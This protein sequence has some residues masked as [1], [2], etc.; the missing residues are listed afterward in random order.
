MEK[1]IIVY[2]MSN[3]IFCINLKKWM[4][5]NQIQYEERNIINSLEH[6]QEFNDLNGVGVPLIV[7]KSNG[8]D[9]IVR[10]FNQRKLEELLIN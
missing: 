1:K 8:K 3:C 7:I 6:E 4:E 10:G 2:T 5:T 9:T